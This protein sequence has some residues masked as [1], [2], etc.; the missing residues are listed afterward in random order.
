MVKAHP[1]RPYLKAWRKKLGRK[2]NW[3]ANE[4]GTSQS[5]IVRQER[6]EIGV[7]DATFAAIAKAYGISVAELSAHPNEADKAQAL[8]RLLTAVRQMDGE[9][10]AVVAGFAERIKPAP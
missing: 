10:L 1:V 7:D 5:N 9:T 3:L 8:D 4:I 6:G 2:Q